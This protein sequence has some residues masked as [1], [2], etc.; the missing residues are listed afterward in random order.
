MSFYFMRDQWQVYPRSPMSLATGG[1]F[2]KSQVLS[3]WC[4]ALACAW[5]VWPKSD[6]TAWSL[7]EVGW[8][9]PHILSERYHQSSAFTVMRPVCRHQGDLQLPRGR[10]RGRVKEGNG[11][12]VSSTVAAVWNWLAFRQLH[13]KRVGWE[14]GLPRTV[15]TGKKHKVHYHA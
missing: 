13:T 9:R 12:T 8:G 3:L 2:W 14:K 15:L 1:C 7:T 4:W 11:V 5:A 6:T 10:R